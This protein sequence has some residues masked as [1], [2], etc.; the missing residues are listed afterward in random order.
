M[1]IYLLNNQDSPHI[2]H[3]SNR[4]NL[5]DTIIDNLNKNITGMY[6]T[7]WEDNNMIYDKYINKIIKNHP[8]IPIGCIVNKII[9]NEI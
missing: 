3:T 6:L 7:V 8:K 9:D 2:F 1:K 4:I 5:F